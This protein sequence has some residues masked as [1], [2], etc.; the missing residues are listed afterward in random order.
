MGIIQKLL[1]RIRFRKSIRH[2][3]SANIVHGIAKA[4]SLYKELIPKV[5][6]DRHQEKKEIAE[7]LTMK[8]NE[9]RYNYEALLLLKQEVEEKLK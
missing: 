7:E 2:D 6:P 4:R 1:N 5:H 3:E 8:I 9:N